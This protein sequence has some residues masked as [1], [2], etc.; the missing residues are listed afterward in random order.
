MCR[1]KLLSNDW[2]LLSVTAAASTLPSIDGFGR[3]KYQQVSLN[4]LS[5]LTRTAGPNKEYR[6]GNG[7]LLFFALRSRSFIK[8][9]TRCFAVVCQLR[10]FISRLLV[11][12]VGGAGNGG[13]GTTILGLV[14]PPPARPPNHLR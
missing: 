7:T 5:I 4:R 13:W 10:C 1:S 9:P 14:A 6:P 3:R 12:Q 11:I 8:H 2:Y